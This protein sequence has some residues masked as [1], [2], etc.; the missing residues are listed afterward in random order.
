M[1]DKDIKSNILVISKKE[2]DLLKKEAMLSPY[3]FISGEKTKKEIII[4]AKIRSQHNPA[5]AILIPINSKQI[6]IS[7]SKSQKAITPGQFAVFIKKKF[8]LEQEK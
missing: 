7:F 4:Q 1:V 6:K 2:G 8:V 3:H 5:R